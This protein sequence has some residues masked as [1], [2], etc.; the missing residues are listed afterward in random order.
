MSTETITTEQARA[1]SLREAENKAIE[2]FELISKD[3]IRPGIT[4]KQ[5]SDEIHQLGETTCHVRT[6]W[7]KRLVRS[8]PNTLSPFHDNPPTRTIQPGD[9]LVIDLGPVFEEWEADFGRTYVLPEENSS[10]SNTTTTTTVIDATKQKLQ[11]RDALEPMWWKIKRLYDRNPSMTGGELYNLALQTAAE[12]GWDWGAT[13]IAGHI[14]GDFPHERI[15][16]DKVTNYI[17]EGNQQRMDEVDSKGNRRHWI[18]EVHLRP[19]GAEFAGFFEQ[20]LTV[21]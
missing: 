19:K 16:R 1:Q 11:L 13:Q 18:L 10:S 15:P 6:H 14:V 20:L 21:D 17:T 7:H 9:I 8:G 4:E 2:L 5:L 12:D 3:L